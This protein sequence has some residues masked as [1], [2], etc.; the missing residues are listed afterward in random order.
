MGENRVKEKG[1]AIF[2]VLVV[3]ILI[4]VVGAAALLTSTQELGIAGSMRARSQAYYVAEAGAIKALDYINRTKTYRDTLYWNV[5][6][7]F[8]KYSVLCQDSTKNPSL[9]GNQLL[10][11][12]VGQVGPAIRR[13]QVR[14][15]KKSFNPSEVPGPLYIEARDPKFAGNVFTIQGADHQYGHSSVNDY[16]IGGDHRPAI[17]TIHSAQS[18]L[19]ALGS[20]KDQ[21]TSADSSGIFYPS[22]RANAD[23]MDLRTLA[24]SFVGEN[25]ELADTIVTSQG[26]WQTP[27]GNYPDDYKVVYYPGNLTIAGGKSSKGAGV[28]VIKGDLHI[29]GQ[30]EWAGIVIVL[31]EVVIESS[32]DVTGGGQGVHIWGT[33]LSKTVE[34]KIAG[35]SDIIWCSDAVKRVQ[36]LYERR[37]EYAF[38][39]VIE[40]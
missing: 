32:T 28:F 18:L 17:T 34:F 8:G 20:R 1:F 30:F 14:L 9:L 22:Y 21:V 33:L 6:F 35:H 12:S 27:I 25:G 16:I 3:G 4:A 7:G 11:F 39:Q 19:Q 5:P 23:T 10:I 31:G 36:D 13:L 40:Y 26:A 37:A 15:A 29:S 24:R 38:A 2:F